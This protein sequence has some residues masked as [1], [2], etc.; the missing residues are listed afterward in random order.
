[1]INFCQETWLSGESLQS[2]KQKVDPITEELE[3]SMGT[4]SHAADET[5]EDMAG[6]CFY[7]Y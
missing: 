1:M 4:C 3:M 7:F 5:D 2:L 6:H